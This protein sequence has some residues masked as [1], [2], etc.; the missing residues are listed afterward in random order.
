MIYNPTG[1]P[2]W[3]TYADLPTPRTNHNAVLLPDGKVIITGGREISNDTSV[4]NR[5]D[6]FDP[7]L[8]TWVASGTMS[9]RRAWHTA[10]L[11]S[12]GNIFIFGGY[13]AS[14]NPVSAVERFAFDNSP[15]LGLRI[16]ENMWQPVLEKVTV[17]SA[18]NNFQFTLTGTQ[19]TGDV[20]AS[21][22]QTNQAA[23]NHPLVLAMR[24]GNGQMKWLNIEDT[25][26]D[27]NYLSKSTNQLLNGPFLVFDFASGSRS[28]GK[29][30]LPTPGSLLSGLSLNPEIVIGGSKGSGTVT[31][32]APA[33]TGG[34]TIALSSD[35]VA[36]K[37]PTPLII[38]EGQT[39]GTFE[40]T[41]TSVSSNT[42][43]NIT[44]QQSTKAIT[45]Q[46]VVIPSSPT[47]P[48]LSDLTLSSD[49][50][51]GGDITTGT[52][53]INI[54][55]PSGGTTINIS[56]DVNIVTVPASVTVLQGQTT[57]QFPITI[58]EVDKNYL[59]TITASLNGI[60]KE[61]QITV[62]WI[63]N[64]FLPLVIK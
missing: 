42:I 5:V 23:T 22:G 3:S 6:I 13:D 41:T 16:S 15:W 44:A 28:E 57:A 24:I 9:F 7:A 19:L 31:L 52:V 50:S 49:T 48:V 12:Q 34:T 61:S 21:S 25:A 26:T 47:V 35:N 56:R 51:S 32:I 10:L 59:V 43:V 20:E 11:S 64:I 38:P 46:L 53:A 63:K 54:P 39:S 37:V 36:A 45:K 62:Y 17:T 40:I 14:N 18:S 55:A 1:F 8:N 60:E 33:P 27:T 4:T 30:A 29:I 2:S 58:A